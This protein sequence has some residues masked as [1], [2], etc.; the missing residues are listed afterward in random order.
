MSTLRD[1]LLKTS[2]I[3]EASVLSTSTIFGDRDMITTSIPAI[4]I[5]LS[6]RLDGGFSSGLTLWCGPSK[7]FKSM[8]TLIML[9][10][11]LDK[12]SDAVA[13]FYDS[14]F[15]T[16]Q[17]YFDAL[18]IDMSRII[19]T[20][21]TNIEQ[22]KFDV[23]QQL[24]GIS[25]G[26]KVFFAIDSIG[27]LA[28]K[29]EVDDAIE[30]KSVADLS[31]A[32]ML[33]S[34]FRMITPH[35]AMKDI[36]MVAVNHIYM[37][38]TG[39]MEVIT[40]DGYKTLKEIS[41]GDMVLTTSGYEPVSDKF[42]YENA[43]ITDIELDSGAIL[44]FTSGHRFMV[45]GEWVYVEDLKVGMELD[46]E[47]TFC[48]PDSVKIKSIAHSTRKENVY[49]IETPT[50]DYILSNGVISHNTQE[51]YSKPV[52]SGG[53]GIYLASDNIM[54]I[55][56][57]QEKDG[58]DLKGWNFIINVEKSRHS[59]E[60][61]KIPVTVL[62]E[63]GLNKYSGLMDM[64]LEAGSATKPKNG[65]YAKVDPDTGEI[66]SKN[67][68]LADT[69]TDAF[70]DPILVSDKF[71]TYVSETYQVSNG[72]IMDSDIDSDLSEVE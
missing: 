37:C 2:T 15:G 65:W 9:K 34:V 62:H 67:Y 5:A 54:I 31:R 17:A 70:W 27:N 26:D 21:I 48:S 59:R 18:D 4:N 11:Y 39:N 38:G 68:R 56:R 66:E 28:S 6:G 45:N 7:H 43:Y 71:K 20:P 55:G 69:N 53:T 29:K 32:K 16:P 25:K 12:H 44:S 58:T 46:L 64:A 40:L 1:R 8:F 23:M 33:K 35:L 22:F 42:E 60:K 10:A 14:E 36:P 61:S 72:A 49:D 51:M 63:G 3:K 41:I 24:E 57:Q 50:H 13:I 30:G 47:V 52:V 19:H